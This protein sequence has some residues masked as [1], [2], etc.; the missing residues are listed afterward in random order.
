MSKDTKQNGALSRR[1]FIT[2]IAVTAAAAGAGVAALSPLIGAEEV[3]SV[4]D[5]L[6]KH[7]QQLTPDEKKAIF[8]RLE[9]DIASFTDG[10]CCLRLCAQYR[11]LHRLP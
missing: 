7:Y 11:P 9:A 4:K 2:G 1:D 5:F 3:P 8:K 10:Q 6:Q